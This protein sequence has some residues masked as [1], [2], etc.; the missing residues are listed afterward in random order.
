MDMI[1]PPGSRMVFSQLV[2]GSA[3][4]LNRIGAAEVR[5]AAKPTR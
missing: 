5:V 2:N 4:S 3:S 1:I